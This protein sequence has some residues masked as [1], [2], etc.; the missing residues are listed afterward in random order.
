MER[1]GLVE[2][3]VTDFSVSLNPLGPPRIIQQKWA[4][5]FD[6]VENYPS[7]NG[8]GIIRYYEEKFELPPDNIVPGNGSTELIYLIPRVLG[9]KKVAIL[10]PCY[11]DYKQASLLAGADVIKQFLSPVDNFSIPSPDKL[12]ILLN[13]V[14]SLWIGRPNNPTSVIF[15]KERLLEL[16]FRFP[17]KWFI[18][19]EAFIQFL[20]NRRSETL[21]AESLRPNILV[22]HSLTKFYSLAGLRLGAVVGQSEIVSRIKQSKEPWSINAIADRCA[23]LLL[24]CSDYEDKT[25]ALVRDQQ[26]KVFQSLS[27]ID[28]VRPFSGAANFILCQW[29]RTPDLDDL[30][31]HLLKNGAYVRDCRNFHGLESNFFRV[32]LRAPAE[33]NRLLSLLDSYQE[34]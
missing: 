26:N 10:A 19:D 11:N 25:R 13:K 29:T 5:L 32:G 21:L 33:N 16:S 17:D 24:E 22:I 15:E 20:E 23:P 6:A 9:L 8:S 34:A 27:R 1:F 12:N 28:G 2:R 3:P 18:V 7:L 31:F 30:L 14:D 4:D